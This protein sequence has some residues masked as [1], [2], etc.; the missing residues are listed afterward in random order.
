MDGYR[1]DLLARA[2]ARASSR[3]AVIK[4]SAVGA[5]AALFAGDEAL[6]AQRAS[7]VATPCAPTTSAECEAI[8]RA[9]FD[10]FNAGDADALGA[11]LSDT[12]VHHGALVSQQDRRSHPQRLLAVRTRFPDGHYTIEDLIAEDDQVAI[13]HTFTGTHRGEF[14]GVAPTGRHVAVGGIH[15]HHIAC[16][17]IVETWNSGDA[18]GPLQQIGALPGGGPAPAGTPTVTTAVPGTSCPAGTVDANRAVVQRWFADAVN[19]RKFDV[20]NEIVALDA[21]LH[22]AGFPDITGPEGL[23]TRLF[24]PLFTGFPDLRF[25]VAAGPAPRDRVVERWTASGTQTGPFQGI[26]PSGKHATWTGINIYRI[27]CGR[28]AEIWTEADTLGRLRQ[29][30]ALPAS[31]SPAATPAS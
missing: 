6:A 31:G 1:F 20:L 4:V 13:R 9:Y 14:Q 16:G 5:L 18:L 11:L 27:A 23:A 26:A 25:E 3:R 8:G 28:I 7:P 30:A 2:A 15:I 19:P 21:V 22:A 10:A 24:E 29:I 17:K 12:Y